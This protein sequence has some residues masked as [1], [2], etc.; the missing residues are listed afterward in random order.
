MQCSAARK[1][2][3]WNPE[4]V[5]ARRSRL[6]PKPYRLLPLPPGRRS[7]PAASNSRP[8]RSSASC[9]I[10]S[11]RAGLRHTSNDDKRCPEARYRADAIVDEVAVSRSTST[12]GRATPAFA[13]KRPSRTC[14]LSEIPEARE[15]TPKIAIARSVRG[16]MPPPSLCY[17]SNPCGKLPKPPNRELNQPNREPNTANREASENHHG[18]PVPG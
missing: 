11:C 17:C 18:S 13:T 2:N 6:L 4:P 15:N 1:P 12:T 16:E 9:R 10:R 5:I 8:P 14:A 7:S 3:R